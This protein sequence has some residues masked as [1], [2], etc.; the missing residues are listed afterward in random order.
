M[1]DHLRPRP[2]DDAGLAKTEMVKPDAHGIVASTIAVINF[3]AVYYHN[4]NKWKEIF[5]YKPIDL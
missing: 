5:A 1:C 3:I 4:D 2:V